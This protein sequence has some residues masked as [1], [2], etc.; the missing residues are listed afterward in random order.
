MLKGFI[1]LS[2]LAAPGLAGGDVDTSGP[3]AARGGSGPRDHLRTGRA[4]AVQPGCRLRLQPRASGRG[5]DP[6]RARMALRLGDA[7]GIPRCGAPQGAVR[8]PLRGPLLLRRDPR[9]RRRLRECRFSRGL[10]GGTSRGARGVDPDT[11]VARPFGAGGGRSRADD[12][13]DG[14][15][16]AAVRP[17][18]ANRADPSL[19]SAGIRRALLWWQASVHGPQ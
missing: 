5:S 2:V 16:D 19:A 17:H 10:P 1:L 3:G 14:V 7:L 13:S 15:G 12:P 18:P 9:V 8:D 6:A 11:C 4:R